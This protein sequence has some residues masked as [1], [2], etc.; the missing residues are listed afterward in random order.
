MGLLNKDDPKLF[1][2]LFTIL[3]SLP[4]YRLILGGDFNL[5]QDTAI[6]KKGGR[7]VTHKRARTELQTHVE[8]FDLVD[9][10]RSRNPTLHRYTW[11][12]RHPLVQCRLDYFL[13]S[14]SLENQTCNTSI[15]PGY[16][17]DHSLITLEIQLYDAKR[18]PS[19]WKLNSSL[20][21][22]P[23][24][25]QKVRDTIKEE[26][27]DDLNSTLNP[28]NLWELIKMKIRGEAVSYSSY[29]KKKR[30]RKLDNLETE[31]KQLH[32]SLNETQDQNILKNIQ[33]VE[34]EIAEI[35]KYRIRGIMARAK[36]RWI[37]EGEQNSHY[38]ASL[39]KRNFQNKV[40]KVIQT[41]DKLITQPQEILE[42]EKSY[43]TKLYSEVPVDINDQ[44]NAEQVFFP[45]DSDIPKLSHEEKDEIDADIE[46]C[47]LEHAIKGMK[48]GKS[49]G[50]DGY[51]AEFYKIFWHDI[52]DILLAS[53]KQSFNDGHLSVSQKQGVLTLLPK[54]GKDSRLLKNWRPISLLNT[55]YK[56]LS[57]CIA[58]KLKP[59]LPKLINEDQTGFMKG[60]YI[61]E[62]IR[63]VLDIIQFLELTNSPGSSSIYLG[64]I[65][66]DLHYN[67]SIIILLFIRLYVDRLICI[68]K[69]L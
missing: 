62:N 46:L 26:T 10:W 41:N 42:E 17:T 1:S 30:S 36:A 52:K 4:D 23:I 14:N 2:D 22:D 51:P 57:T 56:I 11:H 6:D 64:S 45:D 8:N 40:I 63:T 13:V 61:G 33:N 59:H 48:N 21:L 25:Q 53:F 34:E 38:F 66:E 44:E 68:L 12:Q 24:F 15:C 37:G 39:E 32:I 7:G 29:L 18:G 9:I 65:Y 54:K 20:I 49:P 27:A 5:V 35:R 55:D 47:D 58:N 69:E 60:R 31:L 28:S 43:Y 3:D 67:I 16:K 50:N 19:Y